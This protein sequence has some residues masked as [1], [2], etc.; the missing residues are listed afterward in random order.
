MTR[1]TPLIERNE[2]FTRS[3]TPGPSACRPRRC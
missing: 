1:M 2:Q 3:Y